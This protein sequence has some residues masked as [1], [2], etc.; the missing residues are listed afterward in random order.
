MGFTLVEVVLTIVV[1]S[2][3]LFGMMFLFDNVTR[4][5][6]EGDM[7]VAA[8]YLARERMENVVFDKVYRGYDWVVNNRYPISESVSVNG[9]VY[10]RELSIGEVNKTDLTTAGAGS[11]FKRVNITVSWGTG[12]FQRITETT[13]IT[14]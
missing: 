9:Q 14:R 5:A 12:A 6:M 7:N 1:I 3:G 8:T 4:G 2:I 10:L 11:G 13:L